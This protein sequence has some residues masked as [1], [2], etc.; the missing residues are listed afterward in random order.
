MM[1]R[2]I[3]ILVALAY[4]CLGFLDTQ[5]QCTSADIMEP[6]FKFITSSRGCAPF[7]IEVQTLFLNST[8]G[9]IYHVDWGDGNLAEDYIQVNN[10]PNGP[11]ITHE[12]IDAPVECGYQV[13]VEVENICNPLNS[14][15]LEPINVIVWTEDIVLTDPDVFRVCQGFAS[16]ISFSDNSTWNCF[17][18]AD[19]RENSDPR[20]IQW[21]YGHGVNGNRISNVRVDGIIPGGFPYY[22]P[23][24]GTDPIY[25]VANVE[26]LS[27]NVQVPSTSPADIGKDFFITLNNW[28]TCNQYD[29][30]LSDGSLNPVTPGGDNP[31]RTSESRIVIVDTPTPDFVARKENSANPIAWDYCIGDII[32]FENESFGPG[33]SSLAHTWEFYD[34][35]NLTDGLLET[36]TDINPIITYSNGGLKLIRLIVGDNNAVGGCNAVVEKVVRITPTTI[37]QIS[38]SNTKFCKTPGSNETFTVTFNDVSIGS[39]VNTEWKWEFYDE[40]DQLIQAEPS[41]GFSTNAAVP[42]TLTYTNAGVY[43]VV[44]IYQDI[45]THCDI[46]DEINIVVYHNPEPSFVSEK[47]CERFPSE[48]IETTTLQSIKD[49]QVIRW[50]WDYDYDNITFNSDSVFDLS[51]PDTLRRR[52]KSGIHQVAL[53]VTNDQNG[54]SA[55]FTDVIEVYQNPSAEFTVDSLQGCSPLT[56][57]FENTVVST[58]AVDIDE[59]VWSVDYGNEYIDTLHADPDA[60]GFSPNM[61][62]TFENRSPISKSFNIIL[63]AISDNGCVFNSLADSVKVL[64]SVKA[65]FYSDYNPFA[66]NCTPL[67]VNFHVDELTKTLILD[68]YNW[69]VKNNE[70]IIRNERTNS[71]TS[72]FAHTFIADGRGINSFSINLNLEANDMC[73]EDSTLFVNVNPIPK[74]DFTIDTLE[75]DCDIM[76][77]DIDAVDKGLLEY[78]WTINK[79][80]VMYLGNDNGDHFIYEVSRPATG[81]PDLDLDFE[82]QTANYAFCESNVSS[83]SIM[84]SS[85]PELEAS[86]QVDPEMQVYP[87]TIVTINNTSIRTSATHLWDFGDGLKSSDENPSPHIYEEPGQYTI[88]LNLEESNCETSDSVVISIQPTEPIA[89]FAFDPGEG[90][91][92]LTINFTNLTLF[93]N[94]ESYKWD[95]GQG[96]GISFEEHPSHTYYKPGV[97]SVKLEATNKTGIINTIVKRLIIEVFQVPHSDFHIRP[98]NV[99]LPEDPIYT[100]NFSFGADSYFW[101][102]GDGSNSN[103]F[104]PSHLYLDTGF[105]DITLI[106]FT[107]KGCMDT[108]VYENIVEVIDGNEIRVPNAFTPSLDGP[109]GGSRYN[110]G[111]NDV[112]Y[113]VTEG[114]IAYK[115]QI[116]NRWGELLFDTEDKSKGWDGYYKGKVCAPDVY[117]YKIDFKFMDGREVMKFG[118]IMLIR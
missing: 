108:V 1:K 22:D 43:R 24:R 113:P 10:Y 92:P 37:A 77:L 59:Y 68:G 65:G 67:E 83:K 87:N 93:G 81:A 33:G 34:G 19:A 79:G 58:Q 28:N 66:K 18:R 89:D 110:N 45:T 114:V 2:G 104:E 39:T 95:F 94:S 61:T 25:P 27:L 26:Q 71:S 78:N 85:I 64:P 29:E 50:E 117:I 47:V 96:E 7:T 90:C 69:T 100:T 32:F 62:T 60:A 63:K 51:R 97:Y 5:A 76:V 109:S 6:G 99:K 118:D 111:R 23:V 106:A 116:Y 4:F 75:F 73:V 53:R 107:N 20:W 35:P 84:I 40:K 11:I 57:T 44:L 88:K 86:F 80:G 13:I 52:F 91:A 12:Y 72:Q 21:I 49:S 36:K 98:E 112:F 8:P 17:P 30:N 41:T 46:R 70:D 103:E 38:A 101:D 55:V 3:I 14:V 48:M 105:Y 82:L 115:M 31:P 74:S 54:C 42:Y 16:S 56:V 102:F 15:I 9:T